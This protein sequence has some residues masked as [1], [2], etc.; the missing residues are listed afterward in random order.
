MIKHTVTL[1][2]ITNGNETAHYLDKTPISADDYISILRQAKTTKVE[3]QE[4][5]KVRSRVV[6]VDL[7][8]TATGIPQDT[9]DVYKT[10]PAEAPATEPTADTSEDETQPIAQTGE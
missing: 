3:S 9:V 8:I 4:P 2:K 5:H 1:R 10:A 7:V 6:G